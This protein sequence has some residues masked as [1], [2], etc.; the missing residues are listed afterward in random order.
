MSGGT[1]AR[2]AYMDPSAQQCTDWAS[3]LR[4]SSGMQ[5]RLLPW[6]QPLQALAEV[7][8]EEEIQGLHTLIQTLFQGH[9][10]GAATH[11][12]HWS[13]TDCPPKLAFDLS[14]TQLRS[15]SQSSC[16]FCC[17]VAAHICGATVGLICSGH[18]NILYMHPMEEQGFYYTVLPFNGYLKKD[19]L[20]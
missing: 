15:N 12:R 8:V 17:V 13:V 20:V 5:S 2:R 9:R 18:P 6:P 7:V 19:F 11:K 16:V 1:A 3:K 14:L 4:K 10:R